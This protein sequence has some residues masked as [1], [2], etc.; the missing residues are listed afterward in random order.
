M[1]NWLVDEQVIFNTTHLVLYAIGYGLSCI[2]IGFAFRLG[3]K[4]D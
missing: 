1:I 4:N 2:A 3:K